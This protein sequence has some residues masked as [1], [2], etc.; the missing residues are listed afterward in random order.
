MT[1]LSLNLPNSIQRHLQEMADME[2]VPVDQ[3]VMSAVVEKISALTAE[4]Y[5][6]A[7][8]G[9]ADPAAFRSILDKVPHRQPLAGDE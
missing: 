6:R 9:R 3:F 5:L 1:T 8:A 4:G 2:G 7:R